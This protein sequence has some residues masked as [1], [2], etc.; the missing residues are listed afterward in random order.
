MDPA[1][2][3]GAILE[4]TTTDE[5]HLVH[6]TRF[7]PGTKENPLTTEGVNAKVRDLMGPVLGSVKAGQLIAQVN[8]LEKLDDVRRLLALL[9]V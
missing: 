8:A 6:H 9:T 4:I 7:P 5:R 3:R 2:P 1:A